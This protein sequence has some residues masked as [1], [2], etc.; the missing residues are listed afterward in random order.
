MNHIMK[1]NIEPFNKVKSGQ[2]IIESRLFDEK[3]QQINL[4]DTIQFQL[5]PD[6][7]ETVVA[8]VVALLRYPTF[9]DLMNDLPPQYFGHQKK[10]DALSEIQA[11]Y[12]PQEQQ[13]YSVLGIKIQSF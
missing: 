8:K 9:N 3:R 6:L 7:T 1:L 13:K 2:K 12:S 5:Q 4:G 11:F 10:E